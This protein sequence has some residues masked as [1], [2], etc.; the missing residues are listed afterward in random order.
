MDG[1]WEIHNFPAIKD[2]DLDW[3]AEIGDDPLGQFPGYP[4]HW[5][6]AMEGHLDL[7]G[8]SPQEIN[9]GDLFAFGYWPNKPVGS[10]LTWDT[11]VD[12]NFVGLLHTPFYNA[13]STDRSLQYVIPY[14]DDQAGLRLNMPLYDEVAD[15]TPIPTVLTYTDLAP[16]LFNLARNDNEA[17]VL[18]PRVSAG[19]AYLTRLRAIGALP[20]NP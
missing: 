12:R 14:F 7:G 6:L 16:Q 3:W 11:I 8:P 13:T 20:A 9:A 5:A 2:G 10:D 15:D 4:K 18:R 17:W 19:T 1:N